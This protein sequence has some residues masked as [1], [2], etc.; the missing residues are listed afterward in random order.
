MKVG[1]DKTTVTTSDDQLSGWTEE[2]LQSSSQ[3]QIYTKKQSWLLFGGLL[4]V[5]S[6]VAFR[7]LAKPLHLRNMLSQSMRCTE[8]SQG[9]NTTEQ[10][11]WT[12]QKT[13]MLATGVG[14]QNGTNSPPQQCP[15]AH[16]TTSASKVES[17]VLRNFASSTTFTWPLANQLP[18]L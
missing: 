15:T 9:S 12:A 17:I 6:T 2:K 10:L 8:D 13:A 16:H 3:S 5:W 11:N 18:L 14:Q 4:P 1:F 7:I